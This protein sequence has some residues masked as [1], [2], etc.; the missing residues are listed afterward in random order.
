MFRSST[1]LF[2]SRLRPYSCITP[3]LVDRSTQARVYCQRW[4]CHLPHHIKNGLSNITLSEGVRS[5]RLTLGLCRADSVSPTLQSSAR[6]SI[7]DYLVILSQCVARDPNSSHCWPT[8]LLHSQTTC[9]ERPF[10]SLLD[11][12]PLHYGTLWRVKI[13]VRTPPLNAHAE[14]RFPDG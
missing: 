5:C 1:L 13:F 4:V 12:R 2:T 6:T 10:T 14:T 8:G 9:I 11:C 3:F 7:T